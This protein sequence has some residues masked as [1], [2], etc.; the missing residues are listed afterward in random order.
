MVTSFKKNVL[1]LTVAG[2][3]SLGLLGCNDITAQEHFDKAKEHIAANNTPAATIELKNTIQ[4]SPEL[5]EARL[6]LGKIYLEQGDY[7]NAEKELKR[8]HHLSENKA[9]ILP[10]L[11]KSLYSQGKIEEVLE[12]TDSAN[13]ESAPQVFTD[14]M[15]LR[16]LAQLQ[17]NDLKGAEESISMAAETSLESI[18]TKLGKAHFE[19]MNEQ[20]DLATTTTEELIKQSP[21]NPDVWLL[22][23]HLAFAQ[24]DFELAVSSYA[25]AVLLAPEAKHFQLHLAQALVADKK[26]QRAELYVDNILKIAK[27]HV[28]ANELKAYI[29]FSQEDYIATQTHADIALQNGSRKKTASLM[30]GV[31]AFKLE[32]YEQANAHLAKVEPMVPNNHYIKKMYAITQIK[33]GY[34]ENAINTLEEFSIKNQNDSDFLALTGLGLSKMGENDIA[35]NLAN[36]VSDSE[37]NNT[38]TNTMAGLIK[39]SNDDTSGFDNLKDALKLSPE[40]LEAKLGLSYYYLR[41]GQID[42]ADKLS[43]QWLQENEDD[44]QA[45]HLQGIIQR[46]KQDFSA[47]A[48]WYQKILKMKPDSAPA[49]SALAHLH[50]EQKKF[51]KAYDFAY[52]AKQIAPEDRLAT[53]LLF[54]YSQATSNIDKTLSLIDMQLVANPNS[55]ALRH[56]KAVGLHLNKNTDQAITTLLEIP[57]KDRTTATWAFIA[58]L[59]LAQEKYKDAEFAYKKWLTLAPEQ[60]VAYLRNI[61]FYQLSDRL[62][63]GERLTKRAIKKFPNDSR[64][65]LLLATQQA[66]QNKL[67]DA[68]S[69]LQ[70]MS[71]E[72]RNSQYALNLESQIYLSKKAYSIAI[73][74]LAR[75]YRQY[76]KVETAQQLASAYVKI[77]KPKTAIQF[78]AKESK[79]FPS[80]RELFQLQIAEIQLTFDPDRALKNYHA[81][82]K[83]A[84]DNIVA[85]NNLAWAYLEKN[86]FTNACKY[87]KKAHELNKEQPQVADTFGYCL[88]R[89]GELNEA[90]STLSSA[91]EKIPTSAEVALHYAEALLAVKNNTQA[92]QVL[93]KVETEDDKLLKIKQELEEKVLKSSAN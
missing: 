91:Y 21:K 54:A 14:L 3:M 58:D 56:Q 20:V 82:I 27:F 51:V 2:V 85:L 53:K 18:Y 6:L 60:T 61:Q 59:Y 25:E 4:K 69:E 79:K 46:Q 73:K 90:V 70:K 13:S 77:E 68:L 32:K 88:L 22:Q 67:D 71:P 24:K 64:F 87:A 81:I 33:L 55:V 93:A 41:L 72:L 42:K 83:E 16:A 57:K 15:G 26:F 38:T 49:L 50:G 40:L 12:L 30:A 11:T 36:K 84:P 9:S 66:K 5:S 75:L 37:F 19:A 52:K 44:L 48:D 74:K 28:L 78:L 34:L 45:M 47:A 39:L 31:S 76:P 65:P 89:S 86:D 35:L 10:L 1:S 23:G 7:A 8:A 17:A 62:L 29:R 92:Q 63:E 80:S 43:K